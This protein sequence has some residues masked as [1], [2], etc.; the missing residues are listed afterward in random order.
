V[1][2]APCTRPGAGAWPAWPEARMSR[3]EVHRLV[4]IR[5]HDATALDLNLRMADFPPEPLMRTRSV[6]ANAVM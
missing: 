1:H 3:A 4:L 2:V 6:A 5:K